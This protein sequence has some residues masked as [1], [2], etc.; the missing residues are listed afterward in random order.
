M[1]RIE[2]KGV[3][4]V[5]RGTRKSGSPRKHFA[6][7]KSLLIDSLRSKG[8]K[9]QENQNKKARREQYSI[10]RNLES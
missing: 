1:P 5:T 10:Y 2:T 3:V 9:L 8:E 6:G 4:D 7:G